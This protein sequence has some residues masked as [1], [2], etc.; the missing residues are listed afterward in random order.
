MVSIGDVGEAKRGGRG[1][2]G[3]EGAVGGEGTGGSKGQTCGQCMIKPKGIAN[4]QHLLP[5]SHFAGFPKLHGL[6]CF[7]HHPLNFHNTYTQTCATQ[8][9]R[10]AN[11][12]RKRRHEAHRKKITVQ[13]KLDRCLTPMLPVDS[14]CMLCLLHIEG[15][16]D[17]GYEIRTGY[18]QLSS[19]LLH[20]FTLFSSC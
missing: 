16:Q 1:G 5:D 13:N 15:I 11:I 6:Q 7:L 14:I 10:H 8:T 3:G 20:P 19:F 2:E 9:H 4:S 18:K 17:T 12:T